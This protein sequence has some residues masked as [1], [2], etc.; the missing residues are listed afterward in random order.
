MNTR[1]TDAPSLNIRSTRAFISYVQGFLLPISLETEPTGHLVL[2]SGDDKI[3][4][5]NAPDEKTAET[6][7]AIVQT[8]NEGWDIPDAEPFQPKPTRPI[9]LDV[10]V[11]S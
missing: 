2:K 7:E 9:A 5:R 1:V 4:S 3:I 6:L 11:F 8:V 10:L